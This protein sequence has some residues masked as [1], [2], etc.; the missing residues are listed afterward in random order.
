MKRKFFSSKNI[1]LGIKKR[2]IW[3]WFRI[4]W[5]HVRKMYQKK[6]INKNV[7]EICTFFTAFSWYLLSSF[8]QN[9]L[10]YCTALPS[11][12]KFGRIIQKAAKKGRVQKSCGRIR[13]EILRQNPK[14]LY[15][16]DRSNFLSSS[17]KFFHRTGRKV[18]P[19]VGNTAK[20][21]SW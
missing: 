16:S 6:V 4:R 15:F 19:R 20:F 7:T 1:I 14:K 9:R 11:C 17:A 2:R 21:Y 8:P 12:R 10:Y 3:R 18:M 13:A 5:K